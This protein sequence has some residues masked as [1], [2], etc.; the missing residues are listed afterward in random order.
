MKKQ[1]Q[2]KKLET[3]CPEC[4]EVVAVKPDYQIG[5]IVN[6]KTCGAELM[7]VKLLPIKLQIAPQ[8]KEDWGE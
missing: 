8:E 2:L 1:N 5:F 7:I 3:K 4:D 6:C